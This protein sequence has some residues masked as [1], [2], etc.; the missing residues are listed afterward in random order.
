MIEE[1]TEGEW[2]QE[3]QGVEG[4]YVAELRRYLK[5]PQGDGQS[6]QFGRNINQVREGGEKKSSDKHCDTETTTT[7]TFR[8]KHTKKNLKI[9][10]NL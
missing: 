1:Y 8:I 10:Y 3:E 9:S 6:E 4:G 5:Q 7:N 2:Q